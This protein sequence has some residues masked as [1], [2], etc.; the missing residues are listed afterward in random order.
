MNEP[1][2]PPALRPAVRV[3]LLDEEDR[4]LLVRW[5]FADRDVWGTPGGGIEPGESHH[6]AVRRE[7]REETG[8]ALAAEDCGPCVAHRTHL[9]ALGNGSGDEPARWDG[10]E[11]WF[12]LVRVPAF[13][14]RGTLTDEELRAESLH[15]LAWWHLDEVDRLTDPTAAPPALTTPRRLADL[16]R[17][18][19]AD[20]APAQ[21]FELAV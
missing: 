3:V 16:L 14:P 4:A 6:D 19:A 11:E 17:A 5:S 1:V 10:Q 13:T 18:L 12:Y 21:P 8:L 9:I 20:G 7:L 15:E 2:D